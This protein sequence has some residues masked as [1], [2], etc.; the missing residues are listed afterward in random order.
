MTN[1]FAWLMTATLCLTAFT[2]ANQ[3][4]EEKKK[5]PKIQVALCLD[6]SNSM[7]GLIDQAKSQLWKMVNELATSNKKGKSPEIEIALFDYGNSRLSASQG[8]IKQVSGLTS[9]LDLISEKLFELTT[10]GGDEYCGWTI[11]E[12]TDKLEWSDNNNDLK[13]III[14]G[15]EPFN[16]G[17]ID[18]KV[19]CKNAISK[20]IMI[21]TIHCGDYETGVRT[22]WK[23]GAELADG[24]YLNINQDQKVV[25]VK[26]PYDDD[27]LKLNKDLN[28]TY[29]GYGREGQR[30]K[31]RQTTQDMNSAKY[32]RA[33]TVE[34]AVSK[35]SNA[36]KNNDWDMVDALESDEK[37]LEKVDKKTLP[38]EMKGL[39]TKEQK[40]YLEKK[41]VERKEI[42]VN[43]KELNKKRQTYITN[44]QKNTAE[45]L[46]LDNVMLK[47][48]RE[49]AVSK[50][51]KFKIKKK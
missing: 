23:D 35:S 42:Q 45:K 39:S 22:F 31:Q 36:Y 4:A 18:Y 10:R 32:S 5:Q 12:A 11:K 17:K 7:D 43:I 26:T 14:A 50:E 3:T 15:N 28:K 29:I 21:N 2:P 51:F 13:L 24:Q 46:T 38:E 33:N 41:K 40:V 47:A 19:S 48:I 16:Q 44:K 20:G 9:D 30:K 37:L 34:R 49:Q 27:I 1:L 6:T 8:Y 25:H